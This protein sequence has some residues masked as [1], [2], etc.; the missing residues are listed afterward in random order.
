MK[1]NHRQL[2]AGRKRLVNFEL[3]KRPRSPR[4]EHATRKKVVI[5][6]EEATEGEEFEDCLHSLSAS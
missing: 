1:L 3:V 2:Q 5:T 4:H 6:G